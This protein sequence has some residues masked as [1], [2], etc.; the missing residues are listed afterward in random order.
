MRIAQF[1]IGILL[2]VA[3][4]VLRV[5][6]IMPFPGSQKSESIGLAYFIHEN[7][8]YFRIVGG[9]LILFPVIYYFRFGKNWGKVVLVVALVAYG[10]VFYM[11]NFQF[12]ADKMFYQPEHKIFAS[13]SDN[14]VPLE[15]L[16]L[17]VEIDG[18]AKAYPIQLI[19]YHHQ[20]RD[21]IAGKPVMV[22]YC[23]VCR[24][25][26]AFTPAVDGTPENFRL[27]GMDHFNAM[28]EDE[29]TGSWWRQVNG[30][31]IAGQL[32]GKQLPEIPSEQM[33]LATWINEHPQ[34]EIMQP[35]STFQESY[36]NL[37]KYD[38]GKGGPL[39]K[40]DSLSWKDKSWIVGVQVGSV[41]RAYDWN[42]L[43]NKRVINDTL[44]KTPIVVVLEGDSVSFHVYRR[45]LASFKL[46]S[47]G[48]KLAD[49]ETQSVWGWNGVCQEGTR[50]GQRLSAIQSYQEFWHSWSTFR[51]NTTTYKTTD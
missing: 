5:Y 48:S 15:K 47:L 31:A 1:V 51:P 23:T 16:V 6:F 17:G 45:D 43:I 22:T 14:K 8:I 27:V 3:L 28:F 13:V 4:E 44:G 20:V 32:K 36:D 7:I 18:K 40:R 37:K 9:L 11:F 26:R 25:G 50:Q 33:S 12:L 49:N 34:T 41:S 30:E 38:K 24:T 35:D 21:S 19:G 42:D 2:L 10:V 46:D 29:T 39:T